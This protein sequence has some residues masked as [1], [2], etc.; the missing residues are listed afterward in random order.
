MSAR[1]QFV[2][3]MESLLGMPVL[4]GALFDARDSPDLRLAAAERGSQRT[5]MNSG[6]DGRTNHLQ[7]LVAN[8]ASTMS[9]AARPDVATLHDHVRGV[10]G[11]CPKKHVR[12]VHAR[13]DV[14]RMTDHETERGRSSMDL[15]GES[16]R[17]HIDAA[18]AE[19]SVAMRVETTSP[20]PAPSIGLWRDLLPESFND[21]SRRR[22][23]GIIS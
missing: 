9:L 12:R 5:V 3:A 4:N 20:Q 18:S 7:V 21:W 10:V 13:P 22:H 2:E 8:D 23:G 15:P 17:Q 6:L 14:A 11:G 1:E 16:V 19:L